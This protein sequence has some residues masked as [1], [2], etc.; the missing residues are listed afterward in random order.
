MFILIILCDGIFNLFLENSIKLKV[1]YFIYKV[2]YLGFFFRVWLIKM[3]FFFMFMY[4]L[5]IKFFNKVY[6]INCK[7]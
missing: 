7:R 6:K 2:S 5:F 1:L 4:K 3:K